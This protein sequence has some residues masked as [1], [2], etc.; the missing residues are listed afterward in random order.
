MGFGQDHQFDSVSVDYAGVALQS[1]QSVYWRVR[2][3][4]A[5]TGE[6]DWSAVAY[7]EMGLLRSTDWTAK[8][9]E[10]PA[11]SV[12]LPI[13]AKQFSLPRPIS[14]ARLYLTGLGVYEARVNGARITK[15]LLQPGQTDYRK[16]VVYTAYDVTSAL[17]QGANTLG[18]SLGNGIADVNQPTRYE[19]FT[20]T[21][22]TPKL[23]AQLE[24]TYADGTTAR[25]VS[26]A[27]WR[28]TP[29]GTTFSG[30]YGGEDYDA[31]REPP[32]W[33]RP[34][35]DL[36]SWQAALV[37]GPP[38]TGTV[39]SGQ[40]TPPVQQIGRVHPVKITQPKTGH[41]VFDM[42]VD[43][44][45]WEQLSV[46]GPAGTKITMTPAELIRTDG[47]VLQNNGSPFYE[48]YTLAGTG[49]EVW[50][51]QF[52]Y[53]VFR[54]LD[55]T[56]LPSA[57]DVN[58]ITGLALMSALDSAGTVDTGNA[59]VNGAH[60]IIKQAV[61]NNFFSVP[62]DCPNREKLGWLEQDHLV[63]PSVARNYDVAAYYRY[64][65]RNMA[66]DQ[67]ANG[68]V[69]DS[70]RSTPFTRATGSTNRTGAAPS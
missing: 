5:R 41:Y 51:P 54:Y 4:G 29:G 53:H 35:A 21:I 37:T 45:G 49:T 16:R 19:K 56:G 67:Y 60:K 25:I 61:N 15:A 58:T 48:T 59:L 33:Q 38:G 57:P 13:F 23:L 64:L 40:M 3:W 1:R 10:A 18:V 32:G 20:G 6:S 65:I 70:C 46:S 69:P 14:R 31:R 30:W 12:A 63:F 47:T 34:G 11:S 36:T 8:W 9:I 62:T 2:V 55:V 66:D 52:S 28:T 27:S 42:G 50:H 22:S 24:V 26:D 44:S 7:W 39:L 17:A 68:L 43:F